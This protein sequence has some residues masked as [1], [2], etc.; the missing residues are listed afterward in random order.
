[1][2]LVQ[3]DHVIQAFPANTSDEP[4]DIRI[5][6]RTPWGDQHFFDAHVLH[7]LPKRGAIDAV[8]IAQQIPWSLA[9]GKASTTGWAVHSAVGCSVTLKWTTRRRW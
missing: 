1:M 2:A 6:L 4:L 9:H 5:L 8:P 7:P 3:D